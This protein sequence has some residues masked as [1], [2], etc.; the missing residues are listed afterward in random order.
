MSDG[1]TFNTYGYYWNQAKDW[2]SDLPKTIGN[3]IGTGVNAYTQASTEFEREWNSPSN[4]MQQYAEANINPYEGFLSGSGGNGNPISTASASPIGEFMNMFSNLVALG[5]G[6]A[7]L[8]S[9]RIANEDSYINL[10]RKQYENRFYFGDDNPFGVDYGLHAFPSL[11]KAR[12]RLQ[13]TGSSDTKSEGD[14]Y[15]DENGNPVVLVRGKKLS[16]PEITYKKGLKEYQNLTHRDVVDQLNSLIAGTIIDN[17]SFS[18]IADYRVNKEKFD[19]WN[20][21]Y[22][23]KRNKLNYE[24]EKF[25]KEDLGIDPR[26]DPW[27]TTMLAMME[28]QSKS[29]SLF[30]R[31]MFGLLQFLKGNY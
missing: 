23:A 6:L 17:G 9:K 10:I 29:D 15:Y 27:L 11:Y 1:T 25:L 4:Q 3:W 14:Y 20:S 31:L 8:R 28:N 21:E 18:D 24:W 5:Q 26:S 2:L 12:R 30:G 19:S 22:T 13:G 7:D 16:T